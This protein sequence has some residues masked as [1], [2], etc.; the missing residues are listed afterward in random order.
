MTA[1]GTRVSGEPVKWGILGAA[2]I[3]RK[4]VGP[5]LVAAPSCALEAVASREAGKAEAFAAELGA[6]RALAD[7]QSLLDA[8]DIEAIYIPLPNALHEEWTVRALSAGKHVLCEKPLAPTAE[9]CRRMGRAAEANGRILMEAFMYRFHPRIRDAIRWV[10]EGAVGR[11]RHGSAVF[12]FRLENRENIRY[13]R[14][15]AGGALLDVGCYTVDVMRRLVGEEPV[16]AAAWSTMTES[17]VDGETVGLVA[18]PS[19]V[20][21]TITC[22]LTASRFEEV[23]LQG[24]EGALRLERAFLPGPQPV[25]SV[26]VRPDGA[27]DVRRME[28]VD[29]YRLMVEAFAARVRGEDVQAPASDAEDARRTVQVVEALAA[30]AKSGG[31]VVELEPR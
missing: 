22:G 23:R 28:A 29:Q 13:S 11:P 8:D 1:P 6:P 30:S 4:A 2:N 9:A 3:A 26:V 17:G 14:E 12:T 24:E 5:A 31:Q 15:L 21:A 16:R 20:V 7:Y 19:G 25:E 27:R 10:R 18:F